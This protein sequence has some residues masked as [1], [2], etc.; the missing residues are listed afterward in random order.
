MST[1]GQHAWAPHP[2]KDFRI[3]VDGD[4]D[5]QLRL[6]LVVNRCFSVDDRIREAPLIGLDPIE[7]PGEDVIRDELHN[8]HDVSSNHH[9]LTSNRTQQ[10]V[11][12]FPN[13]KCL[14]TI[15]SDFG[16]LCNILILGLKY[17]F[18]YFRLGLL[19]PS[20]P[21]AAPAIEEL[22][23]FE[24][25]EYQ[26]A[27]LCRA[28]SN[29]AEPRFVNSGPAIK[30]RH[31]YTS[32]SRTLI[33]KKLNSTRLRNK[34][35]RRH[36]FNLSIDRSGQ[37][38]FGH[39]ASTTNYDD[40]PPGSIASLDPDA[41]F[42]ENLTLGG[43]RRRRRR[44]SAFADDATNHAA[45][46]VP[47]TRT[48]FTRSIPRLNVNQNLLI[49]LRQTPSIIRLQQLLNGLP[50]INRLSFYSNLDLHQLEGISF[51]LSS[52]LIYRRSVICVTSNGS[53]NCCYSSDRRYYNNE[54]SNHFQI[55]SSESSSPSNLESFSDQIN[56]GPTFFL[57][58][59]VQLDKFWSISK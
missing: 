18:C 37:L 46:V 27:V 20:F 11:P 12:M 38:L 43:I 56:I 3:H 42:Q 44:Y 32:S 50:N 59:G 30:S 47:T 33:S 28:T 5:D 25:F 54:D 6:A 39:S 49:E 41:S 13:L 58:A 53:I 14:Q 45:S 31:Q 15:R 51:L 21:F 19:N 22:Y 1:D 10:F 35:K 9:N 29:T 7:R 16:K 24:S 4:D 36:Q 2:L 17:K 55:S 23:S 57:T 52:S 8:N 34:L 40:N 48:Q 26:S